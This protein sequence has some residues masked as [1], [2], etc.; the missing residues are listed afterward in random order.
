M[1][2]LLGLGKGVERASDL[3]S[4]ATPVSVSICSV[5]VGKVP[6]FS[7]Q[8]GCLHAFHMFLER[9]KYDEMWKA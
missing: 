5:S 3:R 7:E 8:G 9:I 2:V 1:A 4:P 6:D